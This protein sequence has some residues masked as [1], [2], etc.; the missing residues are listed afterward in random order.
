MVQKHLSYQEMTN[1]GC[2]YTPQ[3]FVNN[4]IEKIKYNIKNYNEFVFL[5]SS[6]GY[7][8]FLFSLPEVK[9]IGCDIDEKAIQRI[10][11][12]ICQ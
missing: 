1:Y 12:K 3:M 8:S 11:K 10:Y 2:F 7:G 4:L 9:T 5:D 6:S